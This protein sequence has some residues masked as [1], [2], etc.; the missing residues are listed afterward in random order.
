VRYPLLLV[1]ES[2]GRLAALLRPLAELKAWSLREPRRLESCLK[3]LDRTSL[4]VLVLRV[5]RDLEREFTL[6]EA[7]TRAFPECAVVAV[8]DST[9]PR[10]PGLAWDLGASYVLPTS[11]ARERLGDLV[12][13]LLER[14][15]DA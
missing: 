12:E 14:Q 5:G 4:A 11:A 2:D 1:H 13:A 15:L 3:L 9:H 6:L 7:V 10:L 8:V